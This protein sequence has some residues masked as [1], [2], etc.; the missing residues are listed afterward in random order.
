M[1]E[2]WFLL[3][4][5]ILVVVCGAFVAVEFALLA[6]NRSTVEKLAESGDSGAVGILH[7]LRS[8]STQLSSVQIGITVTNLGIGYLA[9][10]SIARL[11]TPLFEW[12]TI[13]Q[14][15]IHGI[16]TVLA[17]TIATATTMVFGELVPKNIAIISPLATLRA[18][19]LPLR[20]FTTLAM[21]L[22]KVLNGSA[23][24]F[25]RSRGVSPQEE[26]SS[27]RSADELLSLVRRSAEKGTLTKKTALMLERSLNFRE[28]TA[29]DIMTPRVQVKAVKDT[30]TAEYVSKL[31]KRTGFS[32][33]PVYRGTVDN[34]VGVVRIKHAMEVE[35]DQ[36]AHVQVKDLMIEPQFVPSTIELGPLLNIL[37]KGKPHLAVVV[38]EFGGF[39]GLVTIEDL[40]EEL[41]GDMYDEHDTD[42]DSVIR[43][44]ATRTWNVSGLLRP[45]EIA[46]SLGY[47][48]PEED[49]VETIGGLCMHEL[50]RVPKKGDVVRIAAIDRSGNTVEVRLKVEKMEGRRVDELVMSVSRPVRGSGA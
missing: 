31:T 49:D 26:L 17:I 24:A 29:L 3:L 25:L 28:L 47:A 13:G 48:L 10:P 42:D 38:D 45:D 37:K 12:T 15:A 33:F 40:L 7:A 36:R 27:A 2:L 5:I 32:R 4:S 46:Q 8:L 41:V 34:I 21:P 43:K 19:Q 35:R 18:L 11:I 30:E 39:D 9:E 20:A 44:I 1:T 6:V 14:G 22:I 50:E 16:A 23:N